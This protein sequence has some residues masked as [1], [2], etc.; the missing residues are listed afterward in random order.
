MFI[1]LEFLQHTLDVT[2]TFASLPSM[3]SRGAFYGFLLEKIQNDATTEIFISS[4]KQ[5]ECLS[6]FFLPSL[7]KCATFAQIEP[8]VGQCA[9]CWCGIEAKFLLQIARGVIRSTSVN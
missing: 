6:K 2:Q 3:V 5:K 8:T 1:A 7:K 4:R 9:N